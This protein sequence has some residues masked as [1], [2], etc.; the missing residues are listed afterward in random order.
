MN[1]GE[2]EWSVT[3]RLSDDGPMSDYASG[4]G[5]TP[6]LALD[7]LERRLAVQADQLAGR[8]ERVRELLSAVPAGPRA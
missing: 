8:L 7:D 3:M 4:N 6:A 5:E 2:L 1:V